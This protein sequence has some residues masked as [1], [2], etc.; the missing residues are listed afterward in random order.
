MPIIEFKSKRQKDIEDML[1]EVKNLEVSGQVSS[2]TR[3]LADF[4]GSLPSV[5]N[6][7]VYTS[8]ETQALANRPM[9][10]LPPSM[11]RQLIRVANEMK[12]PSHE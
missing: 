8:E 7:R 9:G 3:T 10:D 6:L 2:E 12:N 1:A 4:V 5:K 11:R